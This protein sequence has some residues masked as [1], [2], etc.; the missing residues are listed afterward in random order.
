MQKAGFLMT[1]L[2]YIKSGVNRGIYYFTILYCGCCLEM[3]GFETVHTIYVFSNNKKTFPNFHLK[4]RSVFT[5]VKIAVNCIDVII[6]IMI[7]TIDST[8]DPELQCFLKASQPYLMVHVGKF[9]T[10]K[11][12]HSKHTEIKTVGFIELSVLLYTGLYFR[13]SY[14]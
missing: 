11:I 6:K 4:I 9:D 13:K 7:S 12:R 10:H 5:V 3:R 14:H 8:Q 2:N 1:G